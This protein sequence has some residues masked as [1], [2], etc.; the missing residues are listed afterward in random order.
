MPPYNPTIENHP[1]AAGGRSSSCAFPSSTS[2]HPS[3]VDVNMKQEGDLPE[4]MDF[5]TQGEDLNPTSF[6]LGTGGGS[7]DS[8]SNAPSPLAVPPPVFSSSATF[9]ASS[10]SL[11]AH[12]VESPVFGSQKPVSKVPHSKVRKPKAGLSSTS[13]SKP[14]SNSLNTALSEDG[15]EGP[16]RRQKRLERNRE[17]ARLSRR[18]RKDYLVELEANVKQLATQ[19]DCGRRAH[20]AKA[21]PTLTHKRN[22]LLSQPSLS[23]QQLLQLTPGGAL[24][25][26]SH[27]IQILASF[28]S[29]QLKSLSNP[30]HHK[31]VLWLTL[32]GDAYFR[33]GRA[34]SERLS[35]ARIGER[36]RRT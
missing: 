17:S 2:Q 4:A 20:C 28:W 16:D 30:A 24:S 36:V 8:T 18:R 32:Q 31:F 12:S 9:H 23:D 13:S 22:A 6:D 25:K 21:I 27:Q 35:A 33:G 34:A 19:L 11:D 10:S 5:L 15:D 7:S 3:S 14:R 26:T 29:Q 1:S